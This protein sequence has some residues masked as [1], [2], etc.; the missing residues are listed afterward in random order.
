MSESAARP[1]KDNSTDPRGEFGLNVPE[2]FFY[3]LFQVVRHRDA[4]FDAA[5]EPL[6]LTIARWRALA[7]IRR[8]DGCS[9]KDLSRYSAVD[10]TTLTR[11]VDHLVEQG[12]AART[13]PPT[14]RRMVVLSLTEAGAAVYDRAVA[15]LLK[16]N[17]DLLKGVAQEEARQM[18]RVLETVIGNLLEDPADVRP[19]LR[20]GRES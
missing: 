17:H 9:M 6:G 15:L 19:V 12:L 7:V 4:R 5:L 14:D 16:M 10:R 8:I 1:F 3:L 11:S 18:T 20:F 13:I 2:Q